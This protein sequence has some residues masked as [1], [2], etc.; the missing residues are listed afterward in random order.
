MIIEESIA[1]QL[2]FTT[3]IMDDLRHLS[4][5]SYIM[6]LPEK[7]IALK[8]PEHAQR[9]AKHVATHQALAA[10]R[11]WVEVIDLTKGGA[12]KLSDFRDDLHLKRR[13]FRKQRAVFEDEL[14]RLG[15]SIDRA[16]AKKRRPSKK[17][18]KNKTRKTVK[19]RK[20]KPASRESAGPALPSTP[21]KSKG[22]ATPKVP[23][24]PV[25]NRA[26]PNSMKRS[27][28]VDPSPGSKRRSEGSATP[29]S[30]ASQDAKSAP[31]PENDPTTS[32]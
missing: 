27:P 25:P 28:S 8:T 12:D 5:M 31:K 23:V 14:E 3:G 2:S 15:V 19:K 11:P 4:E 6:L 22:K 24:V 18:K 20:K 32:A 13:A 26:Q 7:S 21:P 10:E 29:K 17:V 16:R 1:L 30:E 9:W